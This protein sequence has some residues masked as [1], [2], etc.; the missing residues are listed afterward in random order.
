MTTGA[1]SAFNLASS[2]SYKLKL[3]ARAQA[4]IRLTSKRC[5]ATQHSDFREGVHVRFRHRPSGFPSA[6]YT[7]LVVLA[8][9]I[10][11]NESG[12]RALRNGRALC[13]RDHG[14]NHGPRRDALIGR[15]S[16]MSI[17]WDPCRREIIFGIQIR[18]GGR[19]G[20]Q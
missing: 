17:C 15:S 1:R 5:G 6:N 18:R 4:S 14:I 2:L 13:L 8:K 9:I 20:G 3:Q 10:V 16:E 19:I 12:S 7:C 11:D